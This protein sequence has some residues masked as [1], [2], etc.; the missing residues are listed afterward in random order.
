MN[1][2]SFNVL[3]LKGN[4]EAFLKQPT[5]QSGENLFKEIEKSKGENFQI[6]QDVFLSRLLVVLD[7]IE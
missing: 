5:I 6:V 1:A 7:S 3:R 4:L 2:V